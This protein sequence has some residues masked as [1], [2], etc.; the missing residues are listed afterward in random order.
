MKKSSKG[1]SYNTP[2]KETKGHFSSLGDTTGIAP[3]PKMKPSRAMSRG[4]LSGCM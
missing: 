1:K 2:G 3:G 4:K